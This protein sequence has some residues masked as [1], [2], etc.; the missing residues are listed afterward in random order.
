MYWSMISK[1]VKVIF[2]PRLAY[3]FYL[4]YSLTRLLD[5]K[6]FHINFIMK[7]AIR[8]GKVENRLILDNELF[9]S[10]LRNDILSKKP[11]FVCRYGLSELTATTV[12]EFIEKGLCGKVS[13]DQIRMLK[14]NSGVFPE[15][16]SN[17][18][19]FANQYRLS[20]K[21]ADYSAY[22]GNGLLEEYHLRRWF[23]QD[24]LLM[25]MQALEPW[26]FMHPWTMALTNMKVIIIHPFAELIK[27]QYGRRNNIFLNRNILPDFELITIKAIQ[28]SG[29]NLSNNYRDWNDALESLYV[30]CM[31]KDFDIALL[32]CGSYAVPLGSKIKEA[33]KMAVVLGSAI[34]IMFGIKGKRWDEGSPEVVA[35]YNDFWIRAGDE[36]KISGAEIKSDGPAYW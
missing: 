2:S 27:Q 7:N 1:P 17:Y 26:H 35:M 30:D 16:Q 24:V 12:L 15:T 8:K 14:L 29:T 34:Q 11:L 21:N 4:K 20:F 36:Y 3:E 31:T 10:N 9:N 28:T 18:L 33:G 19:Y 13:E 5:K 32:G 25:H 22:L 6:L 23:R